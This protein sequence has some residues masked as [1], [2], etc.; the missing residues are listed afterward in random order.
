[1][2]V[3]GY[4][5]RSCGNDSKCEEFEVVF[6]EEGPIL[7]WEGGEKNVVFDISRNNRNLLCKSYLPDFVK[8][9]GEAALPASST[10]SPYSSRSSSKSS[11]S[12]SSLAAS[13]GTLSPVS[14]SDMRSLINE[15]Q[16]L[17]R[18]A[19]R[20]IKKLNLYV[21]KLE[22]EQEILIEANLD[23]GEGVANLKEEKEK[24]EYENIDLT[25]EN[26]KLKINQDEQLGKEQ[27]F[28]KEMSL[29]SLE[30]ELLLN[31]QKFLND[32]NEKDL[33]K[34]LKEL[35]DENE[36]V[37]QLNILNKM[38]T[39]ENQWLKNNFVDYEK[40]FENM[41]KE[42]IEEKEKVKNSMAWKFW[43]NQN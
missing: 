1:M 21:Q 2:N 18:L 14:L 30:N 9:T 34:V 22:Q 23:T 8:N 7:Q 41:K 20:E 13:I 25:T 5:E 29:L 16:N 4:Y 10:T 6:D 3:S 12:T 36:R 27:K 42:L 39:A 33:E 28:R 40:D 19:T 32:K 26:T 31:N 11:D 17:L 15:Y 35:K 37:K 24:L 38:V 43:K